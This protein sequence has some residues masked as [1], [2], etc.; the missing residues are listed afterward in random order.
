MPSER[1]QRRIDRLLDE[2]EHALDEHEWL[3]AR[4]RCHD[5]LRLDATNSD[6]LEFLTVAER[7]I[8]LAQ[9]GEMPAP[10][11][12]GPPL[13]E[14]EGRGEGAPE[15]QDHRE[16]SPAQPGSASPSP[17]VG[18]GFIAPAP[19][20]PPAPSSFANGRYG[21]RKFLGEGGKKKVYLAH[22][23]LLDRDVAFA[24]IKTEGLDQTARERISREAQAM[25]RLG[26][27]PHI[28]TV[29]DLGEEP[30]PDPH[31]NPLPSL[32]DGDV[33]AGFKPAGITQPYMVTELMSGGDV[34]GLIARAPEHKLPLEQALA[35][36][37]QVCE[38]LEFAHGKGI[39]HRD[40]KP[41]N[42]WL[43]SNEQQ[44]T[45][46]RAAEGNGPG[47]VAAP[48]TNLSPPVAKIG[49]FGLAVA[50]DR[51][52]LTQA[53]MMVGTVNYMPPEQA[54]GGQVTPRSD[55]YSLGAM[56]YEMVTG[57]P[58][59]VGD[60]A[61]A[62][63]GQHLNTPPVAPTWHRPDCPPGLEALILR[64]LEKDPGKRPASAAEV[65]AAIEGVR[66]GLKPAPTEDRDDVGA[67]LQP[68]RPE[69]ST[70]AR[71][72]GDNPLY[73]RAF[74]GRESELRQLQSAFDGALSGKGALAM[75]V[76][77]P[78]IGKTSVCEQL[79]TYA[80]LRGGRALVGHCY[81]EGSLSLP[82]LPFVEAMRSYVLAREP[83]GL[84]S[85]LG[86]GAGE[87]AR[88]VSEVRDRVQVA[89]PE[90]GDAD[91]QRWRLLQAVSG[92]LRNASAVQP[93]LIVL[94]DLHDA[95]R[96][97][98]DLLVHLSRNLDGARLLIVGTYR[99][100]EVD[101]GHPLSS[102]LAELRRGQNFLRV[103]L[104]GLTAEEVQ[105]MMASVSQRAIP[106]PLGE[107]VH[108]QTEGN[109]LFVQE[110][111]RYLV[112]EGLVSEQ[113]G[114]L[115]RVGDDSLAGRI[116]EGLRDVIG[117]RLSRLAD[118]TNQV[119]AI[120]SV[121]GR[122]FRLDVLQA[123]A[124][125]PQEEVEGALEEAGNVAVVEQRTGVGGQLS[126][127]FTH[128]F[129]RQ[130]LYEEL[131]A[132]RRIR[133]H[134]QVARALEAVYGR[135][136][137]EH[138]SELA[139]HYSN[140]SDPADL[141]KA[142]AYGE[143][144][145]VRAMSVFAYGE[146]A[147]HLEQALKAQDVLDPDDKQKRC[148]LL[149]ALGEAL[150]P[151]E[152]PGRV[153]A[154]TAEEAFA[155]GEALDDRERAARAAVMALEALYRGSGLTLM[156]GAP[157]ARVWCER[158]DRVASEGT[159]ARVYADAYVGMAYIQ[160][161]SR[162]RGHE[163]LR[164]AATA[165]RDLDDNG[166][167]YLAAGLAMERLLAL[168][169]HAGRD[170]LARS[171]LRHD[172]RGVRAG[173]LALCLRAAAYVLL[174][175]GDREAAREAWRD[176]EEL[177]DHTRDVSVAVWASESAILEAFLD[178][179][180]EEMMGLVNV[181][182]A[183]GEATGIRM[184]AEAAIACGRALLHLGRGDDGLQTIPTAGRPSLAVRANYLAHLG[185]DE[186]VRAGR[187]EFTGI[188]R[189]EDESGTIVLVNLLEAAVL[190]GDLATVA[191]LA[192]RLA[193]L[194]PFAWCASAATSYG[195]LLG[196]AAV[197]LGEPD[198]ARGYYQQAL[199]ACEKIH[200]RPEIALIHLE[201][202]EL[203]LRDAGAMNRAPT[204]G[205]GARAGLKPAPTGTAEAGSR[206]E[207]LGYLDFAISEFRE[208][209]MQPSLERALR[210]KDVLKA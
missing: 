168:R 30:A 15:L 1:V 137:D 62:I 25:G 124:N 166:A 182:R 148:D 181:R 96:G 190:T 206:A 174:E 100:V 194:A 200:F 43:T 186:E 49:D 119:L 83:E 58:P 40:L 150:L 2:A 196:G 204:S 127:R 184:V 110:M 39:V 21:V 22:D 84:R 85:D 160:G 117:K 170:D 128:A 205:E 203:L 79:T 191:A 185:R 5:V 38:G 176:L 188:E 199:E 45:S 192:R 197:L 106:W 42:V 167:V 165:V 24:L 131:F 173:D 66:A 44:A 162:E 112:E 103:P 175:H 13:P 67:G 116:P 89:P 107:L 179:R 59:F 193:P 50:I 48:V 163:Y 29:F 31:P 73:R 33:G 8:A 115:R 101:R 19:E 82:Y 118:R 81:E 68:A 120:A 136:V 6:A 55:L 65:R 98:L 71:A 91:E 53:G 56:L 87:V 41:G 202:A 139:E 138:A 158:A 133:L 210:H 187:N 26:A 169:D 195:R 4:E 134:Q 88:I 95:D 142:V 146:A 20:T 80:A 14:G 113:G 108:R 94:E 93:L 171:A 28:V 135:R 11:G 60:E 51:S 177:A 164:R 153:I 7:E 114:S 12:H 140:S 189:D 111:L 36:A 141:G 155:L 123:V 130:T 46:Q 161:V 32:G 183:R 76:G 99:D 54:A 172:R 74:V 145:A 86:S 198:K 27:H 47:A 17:R 156:S 34:E 57:R 102:A 77:E 92:F 152:E 72:L 151:S 144:A 18:A 61:V 125:L 23:T 154:R 104:R 149:L 90:V 157:E 16:L 201:L 159:T 70:G 10:P 122:E 129:F 3:R 126:F 207:A 109:P 78:G 209:K 147:R 180:L 208:M 143:V 105:R 121:I 37:A 69:L 52:R 63:I 178:G 35:V 9:A 97:T 75:V 132:A 64:L